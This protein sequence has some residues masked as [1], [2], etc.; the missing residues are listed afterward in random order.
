[1][2]SPEELEQTVLEL[3]DKIDTIL[4]TVDES[5]KEFQHKKGVE[6]FTSRNGE[7]LGKYAE[8]LKK[9]NG[10]DFDIFSSAY[11]EYN[12]DF[13]DI[14]EATYVTQLVSE[15]DNKIAQLKDA[16]RDDEVEI[17]SDE[18]TTEVKTDDET[19]E[20]PAEEPKAE[21]EEEKPADEEDKSDEEQE[22]SEDD[23]LAEFEKELDEDYEKYHD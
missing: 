21:G 8:T 11:D 10:E 1:M 4:S 9:L 12:N 6:D 16:L 19:I 5:E 22:K 17:K 3:K 7:T 18:D 2:M 15:I 23:E 14:E 20:T 13:S